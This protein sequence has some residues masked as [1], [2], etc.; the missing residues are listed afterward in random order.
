MCER[1]A[2]VPERRRKAT[3]LLDNTEA[4]G[5]VPLQIARAHEREDRHDVV[6]DSIGDQSGELRG[7]KQCAL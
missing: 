3:H 5:I 1:D 7:D 6:Q 2:G 4:I